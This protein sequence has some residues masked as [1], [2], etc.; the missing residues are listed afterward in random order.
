VRQDLKELNRS[1]NFCVYGF[2]GISVTFSAAAHQY[3]GGRMGIA[4]IDRVAQ[5]EDFLCG[6]I[7]GFQVLSLPRNQQFW[8]WGDKDI[9]FLALFGSTGNESE[10]QDGG[11]ASRTWIAIEHVYLQ[12][13]GGHRKDGAYQ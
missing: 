13:D 5:I 2:Y 4:H 12:F 10:N 7:K 6:L 1:L 11:Q 9:A 8:R 3:D